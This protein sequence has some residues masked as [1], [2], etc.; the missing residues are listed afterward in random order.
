MYNIQKYIISRYL[1]PE[2]KIILFNEKKYIPKKR[3]I[4]KINKT[5]NLKIILGKNTK[6]TIRNITSRCSIRMGHNRYI[7][8]LPKF[9][10]KIIAVSEFMITK[11]LKLIV[12]DKKNKLKIITSYDFKKIIEKNKIILMPLFIHLK[13]IL[14]PSSFDTYFYLGDSIYSFYRII[15]DIDDSCILNKNT[16]LILN[17]ILVIILECMIKT[18]IE[19]VIYKKHKST[20]TGKEICGAIGIVF[21]EN[22]AFDMREYIESIMKKYRNTS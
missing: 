10:I 13:E 7:K 1:I 16:Y 14:I 6:T 20:F 5:L 9:Y 3:H 17:N 12:K 11:I 15:N 4:N 18:A 19:F 2:Y 21:T 22:T 8:I